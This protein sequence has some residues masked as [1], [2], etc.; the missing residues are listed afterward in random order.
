MQPEAGAS[1]NSIRATLTGTLTVKSPSSQ[2][3]T[4]PLTMKLI[5]PGDVIGIDARQVIRTEPRAGTSYFEN[6]YLAGIDFYDEDFPWRY[7]PFTPDTSTHRL[8][9]WLV[10]VVLKESEYVRSSSLGGPSS[11]FTLSEGANRTDLFPVVGQEWAW[12]H[13]HLNQKLDGTVGAPDLNQLGALLSANPDLAYSRLLCP[14]ELEPNNTYSAFL[15]PAFETGRKAGLGEPVGETDN[16]T[17]RSWEGTESNFPIYYE[18]SFRTGAGGDFETLVRSLVP[19]DMDP[20]VGVRDLDIAE[21][22]FGVSGVLNP[23]DNLAG[24]EGALLAPTSVRR[25]IVAGSNFV[26]KIQPILNSP[27]D[28][29]DQGNTDPVLAPPIYGCW[30]ARVNRVNTPGADAVWVNELNLDPRHRAA[31]GL[32]SRVIRSHQDEYLRAAWSQIGDVL[33]VNR[34]IRRAQLAVKAA[35]AAYAK[36]LTPLPAE[37]ALALLAPTL[38]KVRGAT[39]TLAA[40]VRASVAPRAAFSVALVRQLRPQ[41]RIARA[42]FPAETRPVALGSTV[43]GLSQG[44]LT[45][46]PPPPPPGGATV[47]AVN[48]AILQPTNLTPARSRSRTDPTPAQ[49][50]EVV[51]LLSG[52][53]LGAA[54]VANVPARTKFEFTGAPGDL[55]LPATA[56]PAQSVQFQPGD[57][58]AGADMRTAL[59]NFHDLLSIHVQPPPAKP[60]L[61]LNTLHQQALVATA[62]PSAFSTR[63][64]RLLRFGATD[65]LTY[66]QGRYTPGSSND[67][68]FPEVMA[69]P[70]IKDPMS[71]PLTDLSSEYLLPNLKLIP[72]NT[73]SLLVTNQPFIES[74]LAG[75]NH[76]F[77]RDLLW[78]EFPTDQQGSYFRQFWDVSSFVDTLGR[79]P[80]TLAEAL[81]DIPPL[82]LWG[83]TSELGSHDQRDPQNT[84]GPTVLVVRGDLL[85]RYPNTFIYAQRATWGTGAQMNRLVLSDPTG[86]LFES[87]P[88]DPRLR[89]PLYKATVPPDIFLIGF[90]LTLDEI[91]G[92]PR[93]DETA[94]ARSVVGDNVGW[95]FVLQQAVGEPRFGLDTEP[96]LD[97]SPL[98]WDNLSWQNLQISP[99]QSIDVSKAFA[100]P[101]GGTST[102]GLAWG[103]NGADMASILYQE[104]VMVAIHGRTMLQKLNPGT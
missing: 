28:A 20:A 63:Y 101:P 97:P 62:P 36:S 19:R 11:G 65:V 73:I 96:P 94:A 86:E 83:T 102:G 15:V 23:P 85:M 56:R 42:L 77:A 76:E 74:Y 26:P 41:G 52:N 34:K 81:K 54:A 59:A 13:V 70:D 18:W 30:P 49:L 7:S 33:T 40:T 29:Q 72:A 6:N 95:F 22:G 5:C 104:P 89:F 50:A 88:Q 99:G 53:S 17:A 90:D 93:L 71:R 64:G 80:Q 4:P 39:V 78:N 37:R 68:A 25:G 14:R 66:A 48:Q 46:A 55:T 16:G 92:D 35:S 67:P 9:P 51:K 58:L 79:D 82:H 1:A 47:E 3:G 57:T 8:P 100:T 75:L 32:G 103:S 10:L 31:A 24:L 21:P 60:A 43:S 38:T 2:G 69:Y 61:D 27:A 12:A 87:S 45:A 98:V 44:K 84:A 91:R